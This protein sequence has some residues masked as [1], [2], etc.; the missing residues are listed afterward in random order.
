LTIL[1]SERSN[2]TTVKTVCG[3]CSRQCCGVEVTVK[4]GKVLEVKGNRDFP[5]NE[6]ALCAKGLA[7]KELLYDPNRLR[8]PLRKVPGGWKRIS[9][10]EA[11]RIIATRVNQT[12]EK[13]GPEALAT[14]YGCSQLQETSYFI[15]RFMNVYGSPNLV[16]VSAM[17][18]TMRSVVDEVTYGEN[19]RPVDLLNSRCVIVWGANPAASNS[20]S[21]HSLL[22]LKS[23][24]DASERGA[25]VIV[26]DPVISE[27]ASLADIHLKVKPGTDGAL[28]LGL[29]NVIIGEGL[30]DYEF[31]R[32]HTH[33]FEEFSQSIKEYSPERVEKITGIPAELMREA[34]HTYATCRPACVVLGNALEQH[35]DSFQVLRAIAILRA[36]T[37][38]LDVPGANVTVASIGLNDLSLRSKLPQNVKPMGFGKYPLFPETDGPPL[39]PFIDALLSDKPYP[40]KA[41]IISYGN[42]I[43]TWPDTAKVEAGLQRL[44]FLAVMDFYMTPTAELADIVLPAATFLERT[45]LHVMRQIFGPDKPMRF[46][47]LGSKAVNEVDECW[48]DWKFWFELAKRTG[49]EEYFPWSDIEEAIAYQLKPTGLRLEDLRNKT[50]SYSGETPKFGTRLAKGF[51][52]PSGRVEIYSTILKKFGF[53]PIPSFNYSE[54][55]TTPKGG[56]FPLTLVTGSRLA[57]YHHS[58]GRE[59]PSLRRVAPYPQARINPMTAKAYSV[60]DG[61]DILLE[62][63]TGRL[64]MKAELTEKVMPGVVSIPHGWVDAN[65]NFLVSSEDLDP[66]FGAPRMKSIPCRIQSK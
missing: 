33:G 32:D 36:I 54:E 4:D 8:H 50:G 43:L 14:Y 64:E 29:A 58:G 53:D 41:M 57:V 6:G 9:W 10:E 40:I 30:Y 27:T 11:L 2:V 26:I 25:K 16:T 38:N 52:T 60:M 51:K 45:D 39:A 62:T 7:A 63:R 19:F 47:A 31:V 20:Q 3:M 44:E 1:E 37:G 18:S 34:A 59:L 23:I 28:A 55:Q 13:Y 66:I 15:E 56:D 46:I 65:A 24:R 22:N 5:T 21:H 61:H 35:A 17:C 42:P 12:K 49:C 48:P